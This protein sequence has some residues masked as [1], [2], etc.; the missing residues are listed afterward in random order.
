M[1]EGKHTDKTR[2]HN[3]QVIVH[4]VEREWVEHIQ[5]D[6]MIQMGVKVTRIDGE[7]QYGEPSFIFKIKQEEE[8]VNGFDFQGGVF[9]LSGLKPYR[10]QQALLA[11]VQW[12]MNTGQLGCDDFYDNNGHE[13]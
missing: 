9:V 3:G 7:K 1:A 10:V 12:L 4:A 13:G 8:L 2:I 11:G 6:E 5:D